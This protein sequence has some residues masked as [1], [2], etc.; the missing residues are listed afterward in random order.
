MKLHP[1]DA[2]L[3][4]LLREVEVEHVNDDGVADLSVSRQ[5]LVAAATQYKMSRYRLGQALAGYKAVIPYSGW[6]PA[7]QAVADSIG[8]GERTVRNVLADF[9]SVSAALVP[10]AIEAMEAEGLDPAAKKH[11]KVIEFLAVSSSAGDSE[12]SPAVRVK[13][14]VARAKKKPVKASVFPDGTEPS[15]AEREIYKVRLAIRSSLSDITPNRKLEVLKIAVGEEV[16]AS[17]GITSPF[18]V[19]PS[20]PRLDLMGRKKTDVDTIDT[21][22]SA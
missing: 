8:V 14:A 9:E 10:E 7:V 3:Y 16:Y 20:V 2:S 18:T 1:N 19:T 13:K 12:E 4:A 15:K 6:M 17:L 22:V 11:A 5:A 21:E